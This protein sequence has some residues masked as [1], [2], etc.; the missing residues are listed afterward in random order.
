MTP[1]FRAG[2]AVINGEV[3]VAGGLRNSAYLDSSEIINL[4]TRTVRH[5]GH[6]LQARFD[7]KMF[8]LGSSLLVIGGHAKK[9]VTSGGT[10]SWKYFDLDIIEIWNSLNETWSS[11]PQKMKEGQAFFGAVVIPKKVFC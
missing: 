5:G 3:I 1:R 10:T 9:R 8:L 11:Y 4:S 7:H 2:C 6:L